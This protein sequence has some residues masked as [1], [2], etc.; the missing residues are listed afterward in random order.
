MIIAS[1]VV[2]FMLFLLCMVLSSESRQHHKSWTSRPDKS[3]AHAL[4]TWGNLS[5]LRCTSDQ[6]TFSS[7]ARR[8]RSPKTTPQEKR[9]HHFGAAAA[10]PN[11]WAK[12][13]TTCL[14]EDYR[15]YPTRPWKGWYGAVF[16]QRQENVT[17]QQGAIP[18]TT[19]VDFA[20]VP[21]IAQ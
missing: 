16:H 15:T 6:E 4:Q 1:T 8:N 19:Q 7:S 10:A 2:Y 18:T 21:D 13:G 20:T 5:N 17:N 12:W 11:P 9:P 3:Q 14:E